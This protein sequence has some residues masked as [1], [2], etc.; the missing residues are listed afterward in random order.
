MLK[1]FSS[2]SLDKNELSRLHQNFHFYS[3]IRGPVLQEAKTAPSMSQQTMSQNDH[4]QVL[5]RDNL[6][7]TSDKSISEIEST[8]SGKYIAYENKDKPHKNRA[9]YKHQKK[10]I[11]RNKKSQIQ[12]LDQMMIADY[13]KR[14]LSGIQ[15]IVLWPIICFQGS[16]FLIKPK[17][18]SFPQ[19]RELFVIMYFTC[20][21]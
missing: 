17:T 16:S 4:G 6:S 7:V 10:T 3:F 20:V 12:L 14:E 15:S 11:I 5:Q 2:T 21:I 9:L 19:K 8:N 13:S 18:W 1:L